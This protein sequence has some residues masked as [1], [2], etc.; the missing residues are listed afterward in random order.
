MVSTSPPT[1]PLPSPA[2]DV[3][4]TS[5]VKSFSFPAPTI[6]PLLLF[7]P[8]PILVLTSDSACGFSLVVTL[9]SF[10]FISGSTGKSIGSVL[11]FESSTN[12]ISSFASLIFS[13]SDFIF[14]SIDG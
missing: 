9:V 10:G 13:C 1:P 3:L 8:C 6:S 2:L 7:S 12:F 14:S 5:L 4:D 11:C